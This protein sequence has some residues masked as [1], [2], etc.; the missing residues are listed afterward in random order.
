MRFLLLLT[1]LLG[2]TL[3]PRVA[4]ADDQDESIARGHFAL[5]RQLYEAKRFGEALVEFEQARKAKRLPAFD[6]NIGM[7]HA[8]LGHLQQAI[9]AFSAYRA[10]TVG[11]DAADADQRIADLQRKLDEQNAT[12]KRKLD[13]QAPT[14][15]S[16]APPTVIASAPPPPPQRRRH[17]WVW[18]VATGAVVVVAGAVALGLVF[19]LPNNAPA[20]RGTDPTAT[21]RF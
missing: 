20:Q 9:D 6:Y 5:G 12:E 3:M 14:A 8:Q 13:A 17:A 4:S 18:G 11:P 21:V 1:L 2:V 10:A 7:C 19:G 16:L 15:A